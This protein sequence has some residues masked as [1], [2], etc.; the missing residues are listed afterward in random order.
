MALASAMQE[1]RAYMHVLS[2]AYAKIVT[3]VGAGKRQSPGF[4]GY[5]QKPGVGTGDA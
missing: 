2:P 4:L 1:V 5:W 3:P